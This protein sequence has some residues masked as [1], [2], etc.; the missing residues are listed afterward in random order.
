MTGKS[1]GLGNAIE[2][3]GVRASCEFVSLLQFKSVCRSTNTKEDCK[4]DRSNKRVVLLS[5]W[6]NLTVQNGLLQDVRALDSGTLENNGTIRDS[7]I[8]N[9][10]GVVE[11]DTVNV[12][13][14]ERER[15]T[16]VV[17]HSWDGI[18]KRDSPRGVRQVWAIIRGNRHDRNNVGK[19][20]ARQGQKIEDGGKAKHDSNECM[21]VSMEEKNPRWNVDQTRRKHVHLN[22]KTRNQ[23]E[24]PIGIMQ[25]NKFHPRRIHDIP[26]TSWNMFYR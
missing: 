20:I 11:L 9:G 25:Q 15:E 26:V 8:K 4:R 2:E 5:R 24:G 18:I 21:S 22:T 6:K 13:H 19:G 16:I 12:F 1:D 23:F 7:T 3:D 17:I 14:A 10:V